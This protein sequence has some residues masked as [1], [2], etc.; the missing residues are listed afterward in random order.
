VIDVDERRRAV[1]PRIG[2]RRAGDAARQRHAEE[3]A[4]ALERGELLLHFQ[5]V[6]GRERVVGAEVLVRWNH[7]ERGLLGPDEF[8]PA[9]E[10]GGL[11]HEVGDWTLR[12][13][14]RQIGA[15]RAA[16]PRGLWFG[17]NVSAAELAWG[18]TYV[19]RL[20]AEMEANAVDGAQLELEV[21]ERLLMTHLAENV[22]T[23][24][25]IGELGVRIAIDDFGA[26]YSSLAY[27]RRLPIDKLKIDR[28]FLHDLESNRDAQ[29]IVQAIAAMAKSLGLHIAAEGVETAAQLAH[30]LALGCEEWQGHH[31]SPPLDAA[32]FERLMRQRASVA[33]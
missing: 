22:K 33:P 7:P 23:L 15:W 3:M 9:A 1:P 13:A 30:L 21:T 24:R 18:E 32:A 28:L 29:V 12:H 10:E 8:I 31:F 14:L 4:R 5:P 6:V 16:L 26:G 2:T 11:I 19:G 25:R 27:L 17:L 20:H